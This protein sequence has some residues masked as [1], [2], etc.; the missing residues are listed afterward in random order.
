MEFAIRTNVKQPARSVV[1]AGTKR[2]AVGEELDGIDI[3]VVRRERLYTLLLP[4]V[5]KLGKG[6]TGAGDELV[7]VERIDTQAHHI[8]KMVCE[9]MNSCA[10]FDVP[11]NAGHITGGS[12]NST[13]VDEA[14]AGQVARVPGQFPRD[15]CGPVSRSEVVDGADV[16]EATAS[17][18]VA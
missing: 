4:N 11:K 7:V 2:V 8:T 6:I 12:E 3:R 13:V 16:V 18:V 9:F 1:G 17:N 5:P 10:G 15:S 14:T